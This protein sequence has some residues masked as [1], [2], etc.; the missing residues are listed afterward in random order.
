MVGVVRDLD[1]KLVNLVTTRAALLVKDVHMR[2]GGWIRWVYLHQRSVTRT[3]LSTPFP[4]NRTSYI[5]DRLENPVPLAGIGELLEDNGNDDEI[6]NIAINAIVEIAE[7][8]VQRI[9]RTCIT[10]YIENTVPMYTDREFVMH[11]RLKRTLFMSMVEKFNHWPYF[12]N[13]GGN[14]GFKQW[15]LFTIY[16]ALREI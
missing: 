5:I 7:G 10:N 9:H 3:D 15:I 12:R 16:Y 8:F 2:N 4:S 13:L 6:E 1:S 14:G 11:F